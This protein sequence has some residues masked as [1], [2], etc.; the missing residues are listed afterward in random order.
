M[1]TVKLRG[2]V[3]N[4]MS[5]ENEHFFGAFSHQSEDDGIIR[6][7]VRQRRLPL[8]QKSKENSPQE[9]RANSV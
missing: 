5:D 2:N 8:D 3:W 7:E 1:T 4:R 9:F 6:S